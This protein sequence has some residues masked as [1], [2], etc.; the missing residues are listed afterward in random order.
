MKYF[1]F[2]TANNEKI[3]NIA[4]VNVLKFIIKAK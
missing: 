1:F 3:R 2:K 4:I